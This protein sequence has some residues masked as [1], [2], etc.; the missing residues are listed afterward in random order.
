MNYLNANVVISKKQLPIS[1]TAI[2]NFKVL[3]FSSV[4]F[5]S[6]LSV[7]ITYD[8]FELSP[9]LQWVCRPSSAALC[10]R[11]HGTSEYATDSPSQPLP[12]WYAVPYQNHTS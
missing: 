9:V 3:S 11:N 7:S 1:R 6:F 2:A 4:G 12:E 5:W 10:W 8:A